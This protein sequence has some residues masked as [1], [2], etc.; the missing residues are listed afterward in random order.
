MSEGHVASLLTALADRY[1]SD[2]G[3]AVQCAHRYTSVYEALLGHVRDKPIRLLEIGLMHGYTQHVY[4]GK[5]EQVGCPSLR[6]WSEYLPNATIFGFDQVDFRGLAGGRVAIF[7]GDQGSPADLESM[8]S[9]AG[10]MFDVIIDDGSHA[11]HHQQISLGALFRHL[12]PGGIYCIEDLHY[13]PKELELTGISKTKDFLRDLRFG[14]LGSR[15]A[16]D[17]A[18]F[19]YLSREVKAIHFFDSQSER[20]PLAAREDALGVLFRKGTHAWF[21]VQRFGIA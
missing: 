8:A 11:S 10:G 1:G 21:D 17:Q 16:M 3:G 12:A 14:R 13:Q 18:A 5:F 4:Q 2:K 19:E 6:M 7:C 9:A 20:W 15:V